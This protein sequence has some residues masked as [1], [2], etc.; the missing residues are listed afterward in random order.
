[1]TR[2]HD[3]SIIIDGLNIVMGEN[4]LRVFGEVWNV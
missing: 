2:L 3:A 4:W 1:M